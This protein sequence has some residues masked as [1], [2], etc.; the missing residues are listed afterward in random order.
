[1]GTQ[2]LKLLHWEALQSLLDYR[3]TC[4]SL[5]MP[6]HPSGPNPQQDST[7]LKKLL[8]ESSQ[9]LHASESNQA[10]DSLL[11]PGYQ[12]LETGGFRRH[13]HEG[14]AL[15]LGEGF[16]HKFQLRDRLPERVV[17]GRRFNLKLL[18]APLQEDALFFVLATSLGSLRLLR[19][20]RNTVE[21]VALE[22]VAASFEE[23]MRF[24]EEQSHLQFHTG[25]PQVPGGRAA[26]FHG[27]SEGTD[28]ARHKTNILN[29]FR[30][31]D[32]AV[33][34]L[35]KG[36]DTPL[37]FAGVESL[38]GLYRK[39]NSSRNLLEESVTWNPQGSK[40]EQLRTKAWRIVRKRL[41]DERQQVL[42]SC[43]ERLAKRD[44]ATKRIQNVLPASREGRVETLLLAAG[45]ELWGEFDSDSGSVRVQSSQGPEQGEDL[46]DRA[47]RE[48]LAHGGRLLVVEAA[49]MPEKSLVVAALRY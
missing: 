3:G 21:P 49:E 1:M 2:T 13:G 41:K 34:K 20:T 40:P 36:S 15:F 25:S 43:A 11:A 37:V 16:F 31:V 5:Y 8:N 12:L 35:L 47:A 19:C 33:G 27:H 4:V 38:L 10:V 18:L 24:D 29:W 23:A 26:L 32:T 45:G 28:E 9:L 6:M 39:A 42:T 17:V 14:L 46:L 7:R 44:R 30:K 22:G 48:T